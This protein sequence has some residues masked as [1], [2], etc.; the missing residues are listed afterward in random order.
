MYRARVPA[1][2]ASRQRDVGAIALGVLLL[3]ACSGPSATV[4]SPGPGSSSGA[5]PSAEPGAAWGPLAVIPPQDGADT[6]RSQGTLRVTDSCVLL[7]EAG[8]DEALLFWPADRTAWD[9]ESE[10]ITFTNFDGSVV[11]VGDRDEVVLGGGGDSEAESGVSADEWVRTMEWVAPPAASCPLE[12]RWG[13][14]A[15]SR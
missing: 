13:V 4:S 12:H 15:V 3:G 6:G 14:G 7:A 11:T 9:A 10:T 2:T 1:T 8:G 5:S